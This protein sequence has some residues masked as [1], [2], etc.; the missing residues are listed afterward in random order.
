[1]KFKLVLLLRVPK[2]SK[3]DDKAELCFLY[4]NAKCSTCSEL[5][6]SQNAS[7]EI[8]SAPS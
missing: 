2:F 1:M 3:N 7:I 6:D 8:P 4:I 5:E